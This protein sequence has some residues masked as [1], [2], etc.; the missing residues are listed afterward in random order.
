MFDMGPY[1]LSA[2]ITLLGPAATAC[3]QVSMGFEERT[4]TSQP[5]AGKQIRPEVPTHV[6]GQLRF[7]SGASASIVTSF[8]VYPYPYPHIVIFGSEG[9][10]EVPDPNGFGGTIRVSKQ[11]ATLE[12]VPLAFPHAENSRG[13]GVV[14]LLQSPQP[15]AT[16]ALGLHVL[17]IM[18]GLHADCCVNI[19]PISQPEPMP[20]G[21][22]EIQEVAGA[23]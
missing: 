1:Y 22:F 9:N 15:R 11:G 12:E 7:V 10:L 5:L 18:E 17:E 13:L 4:I 3:G 8:D 23:S 21:G 14:D 16:G 6:M 2:L 19:R 20:V